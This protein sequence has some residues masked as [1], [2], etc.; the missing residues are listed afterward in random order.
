MHHLLKVGPV[1]IIGGHTNIYLSIADDGTVQAPI[2]GCDDVEALRSLVGSADRRD[3]CSEPLLT[4]AASRLGISVGT[5]PTEALHSR[6]AIAICVAWQERALLAGSDL[7]LVMLE[8]AA[9]FWAAQPWT[10]RD[11]RE[12]LTVRVTGAMEGVYEACVFAK[13]GQ[14]MGLVLC[15]GEGGLEH[16]LALQR[17]GSWVEARRLPAIG[18]LLDDQPSF[19]TRALEAAGLVP[20]LPIPVKSGAEG[21]S[22][23]SLAEC[24]ALVAGLR[25]CAKMG[26]G[27]PSAQSSVRCQKLSVSVQVAVPLTSLRH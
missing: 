8:A 14:G 20:R 5:I 22:A 9:E 16:F 24:L 4:R 12:P 3:F 23:P 10:R 2:F 19:V 25:A 26:D 6:A 7:A 15:E 21:I 27:R 18:V 17:Q 13:P 11:E 1:D